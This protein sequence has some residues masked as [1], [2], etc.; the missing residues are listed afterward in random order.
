MKVIHT[1][2]GIADI[3]FVGT[4][5]KSAKSGAQKKLLSDILYYLRKL[6]QLAR[7]AYAV[8]EGVEDV[9]NY[10]EVLEEISIKV[11]EFEDMLK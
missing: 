7:R 4:A 11:Q 5:I 2:E 1:D 9:N 8:S 3:A 10:K 6:L